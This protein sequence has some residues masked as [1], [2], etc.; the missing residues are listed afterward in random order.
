[1]LDDILRDEAAALRAA[2]ADHDEA[3][4]MVRLA[5][6]ISADQSVSRP[7]TGRDRCG[8]RPPHS[9]PAG[10]RTGRSR[11][12]PTCPEPDTAPASVLADVQHLCELVLRSADVARLAD[13]ARDYDE[14]GARTFGCLLYRL[15]RRES[16][17]YWWRFAAGAEDQLAA[18]LLASHHAAVGC[19]PH[20]RLWRAITRMLGFRPDVHLPRPVHE[21]D[22]LP[23]EYVRRADWAGPL[24]NFLRLPSL[25]RELVA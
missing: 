19:T 2:L 5:A 1:M 17:L 9:H 16:A 4:F 7:A 3:A 14:A 22:Y 8:T 6:R 13:F 18:H 24:R 23:E 21:L 25:P 15:G 10:R 20:A 12:L 11:L